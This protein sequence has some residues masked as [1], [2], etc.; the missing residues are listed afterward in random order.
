MC[1]PRGSAYALLI[2][3]FALAGGID[4]TTAADI[5]PYI[6]D[7]GYLREIV[8]EGP[9]APGDFDTFVRIIRENQG[10]VS[11]VYC[12]SPGGNFYEAMKIGRAMRAFEL[13]SQAPMRDAAGRPSCSADFHQ[14]TPRDP[15]NCTCAS[16]GFFIHIGATHRGGTFLAVHRPYFENGT[17]GQLSLSDAR[18]ALDDLQQSARAYMTEMGVP[19]HIQDDVLNT[20]SDR[21]LVLDETTVKT[22]F[23]GDLTYIHEWMK[24]KC[25]VLSDVER[26]RRESYSRRLVNARSASTT[27]LSKAEWADL[28]ALQKKGDQELKCRA[29]IGNQRRADAYA[30]YFGEQPKDVVNQNFAKWS[31]AAKYLGR[32]Y[33]EIT[34]E[35]KFDETKLGDQSSLERAATATAPMTMLF[36][37][38]STPRAVA[39]VA[40]IS[41]PNPSP[42]FIQG[43]VNSLEKAWGKESGGNGRTEWRWGGN[44]FTAILKHE[45]TSAEGPY[46]SLSIYGK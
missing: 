6:L 27:D 16:A 21:A 26:E 25:L 37:S 34:S 7:S 41:S 8:I 36:D 2:A 43:V 20:A 44:D 17:L 15:K 13:H 31:D 23:W 11:G 38:V 32:R 18:K 30:K 42:A 35:E 10:R 45:P 28:D 22:N 1:I 33:Y 29:S 5:R 14:P 9:I 19:V 3:T 40:V 39:H 24:D 4:E 46:L 12:F